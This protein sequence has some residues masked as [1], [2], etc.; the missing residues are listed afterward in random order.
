MRFDVLN[1]SSSN[2]KLE[3]TSYIDDEGEL[4][5]LTHQKNSNYGLGIGIEKRNE[6]NA[7]VEFLYG[8]S[9]IG[10]RTH[11]GTEGI[12]ADNETLSHIKQNAWSY[13]LGLNLGVLIKVAN[14][15]YVAG[16]LMPQYLINKDKLEYYSDLS[17]DT[18]V[19]KSSGNSFNFD[20]K[21]IRLSLVYR[22]RR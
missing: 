17:A 18:R 5:D 8:L 19:Q 20:L 10:R 1:A 21:D 13:G 6:F 15:L 12:N 11:Q 16:E 4:I 2:K 9:L 3:N 7:H 14:N 22:F